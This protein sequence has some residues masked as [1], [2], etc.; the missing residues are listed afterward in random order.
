MA[1]SGDEPRAFK[2]I[3]V[4]VLNW[5][6]FNS[7]AD[8]KNPSWFRL[9][10]SLLEDHEFFDF[11]H[12]ELIA[13]IYILSIASKKSSARIVI[14]D[15]HAEKVG[16]VIKSDLESA[17]RKLE[18]NR[19]IKVHGTDT[20]RARDGDVTDASATLH[21]ITEHNKTRKRVSTEASK[22]DCFGAIVEFCGDAEIETFL[23]DLR[24]TTQLRWIKLYSD[25]Q[26]IRTELLKAIAWIEINPKKAPKKNLARFIGGWLSRGWESYRKTLTTNKVGGAVDWSQVNLRE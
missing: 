20:S 12:A 13:W 16:R 15:A 18:R 5:D 26:W 6:T 22:N 4:E 10:H 14:Y 19:C 11:T 1:T 24:K 25:S 9:Q 7:R 23:K 3:L 2:G 8:V 17:F 21:N